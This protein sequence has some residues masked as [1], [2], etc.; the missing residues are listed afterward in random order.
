MMRMTQTMEMMRERQ[1]CVLAGVDARVVTR[2]CRLTRLCRIGV[3]SHQFR[4]MESDPD[5]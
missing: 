5:G 2:D 1:V 3:D 4:P